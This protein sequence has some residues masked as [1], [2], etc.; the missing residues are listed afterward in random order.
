MGADQDTTGT[1]LHV[2]VHN[3]K[4]FMGFLGRDIGGTK[5]VPIGSWVNLTYTYDPVAQKGSLYLNGS[6]DKALAQKPY[7]GPLETI[8][9][10]PL[11]NHGSYSL[12]EAVVAQSCFTPNMVHQLSEKGLESFRQGDYTSDWRA[13]NGAPQTL[14]ATADIPDGSTITVVVETGDQDG[15]AIGSSKIELKPGKQSYPL[16]GLTA[17]AQVRLRVQIASTVWGASPVLRAA[18]ITGGNKQTWSTPVDWARGQLPA[19]LT[20]NFGQ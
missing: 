15:K 2:G 7:A 1:Q 13:L 14:D 19:S 3:K 5:E 4:P 20:G 16:T 12:D 18:T 6:L 17:G 10:A 11:L 8:G 9:D